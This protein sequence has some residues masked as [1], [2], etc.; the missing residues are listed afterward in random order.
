M[1]LR[2]ALLFSIQ[3]TVSCS[4]RLPESVGPSQEILVLADPA[5]W[6]LLEEPLREVFEK[7]ILTPQKEKIFQIQLGSIEDLEEQKHLRR[8][9]LLIIAPVDAS[10]STAAFMRDLLDPQVQEHIRQGRSSIYW[11]EDVWARNQLFI[12]LS[13]TDLITMGDQIRQEGDRLYE[14]VEVARNKRIRQL[15]YRYG[16]RKDITEQLKRDFGWSVRVAFG[17]RLLA[18][19]PDSGFAVLTKE[20]PSRWL[21]VFWED[22]I[23]P[24]QLSE[25]W[26]IRKRDEI[27]KRFFDG[28]RVVP[29]NLEIS[30]TDFNGR[31]AV[32]MGGTWENQKDWTGGPF[33][34]YAFVD[35]DTNRFY[36]IDMGI[37]SPNK[38]KEPYLRQID[39]MA[40]TFSLVEESR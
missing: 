15:I 38:L 6:K 10:H 8:K 27:T 3:L 26:C 20:E 33:R 31:L 39:L 17:Y 34:S 25:E 9:N 21:F 7:T 29:E 2:I 16:E 18:S 30:Q 19:N 14:S 23:K 4:G 13:G 5:D 28:D 35:S 40:R 24:H 1:M 32:T 22:G 12:T 11:K 37:F 36:H